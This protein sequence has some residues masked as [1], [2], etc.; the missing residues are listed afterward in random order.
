MK[1]DNKKE[2][3]SN[4]K[5]TA[6]HEW[7]KIEGNVATIGISDY[8]ASEMGDIVYVQLPEIGDAL[9]ADEAFA[10][11]E[12]VKAV[13]PVLSPVT[14][15]VIEVNSEIADSPELINANAFNAWFIKAEIEATSELISQEEYQ[16]LIQK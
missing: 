8:A 2:I 9:N 10:E 14:G 3:T 16:K 5:F 11:V 1:E 4:M 12:S 13:S 6:T 15:K 7:V